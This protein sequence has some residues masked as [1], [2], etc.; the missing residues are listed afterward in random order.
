MGKVTADE[1]DAGRQQRADDARRPSSGS[2]GRRRHPAATGRKRLC[3]DRK[4]VLT[5]LGGVSPETIVRWQKGTAGAF[6]VNVV[7]VVSKFDHRHR[8]Y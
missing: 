6:I 3:G 1:Y 7:E 2:R 8:G 5:K 4:A